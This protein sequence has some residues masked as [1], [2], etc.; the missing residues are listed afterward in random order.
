MDNKENLAEYVL[1]QDGIIFRGAYKHP[2]P[3]P[4]NFGQVP[5]TT[6]TQSACLH[7]PHNQLYKFTQCQSG[8]GVNRTHSDNRKIH[9]LVKEIGWWIHKE[10][11]WHDKVVFSL[12]GS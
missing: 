1:A 2:I 11:G 4:W 5:A 8:E 3:T 6:L 9:L 7:Y 12:V 10:G